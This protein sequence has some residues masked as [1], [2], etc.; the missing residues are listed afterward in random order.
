MQVFIRS[1]HF[2]IVRENYASFLGAIFFV[3][4]GRVTPWLPKMILPRLVLLSPLPIVA[5]FFNENLK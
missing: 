4:F 1:L 5:I 3:V 2:F